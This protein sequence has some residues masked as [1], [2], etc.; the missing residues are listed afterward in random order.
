MMALTFADVVA[1]YLFNR[2]LSGAFELTEL[3]LLVLIFA[4]LP[5]VSYADEHVTMDF[6]DRLVSEGGRRRLESGVHVINAAVMTLLAWL[7]WSTALWHPTVS[8]RYTAL[9]LTGCAGVAVLGA[10]RPGVAAWHFVPL[11]LLA[12]LLMPLAEGWGHLQLSP[13]RAGFLGATLASETTAAATGAVGVVR[14]DPM[15]MLPFCG[16]NMGDYWA[17]WLSIAR[18]A[19]RP[20]KIFRVNWFQR[21][22][23]GKFIWPGFGENLRVLRWVIERSKGSGQA[24]ETPIGYVPKPSALNGEGLEVSQADLNQLVSVDREAWKNNLKSQGDFFAT[25]GDHLPQGMKEEHKALAKRLN[26]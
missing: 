15:A 18:G 25:F 9:C 10:R 16:Y 23:Q 8:W 17:H 22:D 5:L 21:N 13:V 24:D 14:R 4:G 6:V 20:P 19:T 7:V 3:L 2:P 11:G 1:R 12:V 26:S